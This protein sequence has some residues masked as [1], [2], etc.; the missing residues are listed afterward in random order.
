MRKEPEATEKK[1]YKTPA[2]WVYGGIEDLTK[3]TAT[4]GARAD[5]RGRNNDT[6]TH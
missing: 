1:P 5:T 2:L 4:F 3:A 6:R